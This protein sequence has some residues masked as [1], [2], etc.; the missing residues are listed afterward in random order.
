MG[1][2]KWPNRGGSGVGFGGLPPKV[3]LITYEEESPS[4]VS[5]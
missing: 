4:R 3:T 5:P 2:M 1:G